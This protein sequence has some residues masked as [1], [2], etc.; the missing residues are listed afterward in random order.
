MASCMWHLSTGVSTASSDLRVLYRLLPVVVHD[1]GLIHHA[2]QDRGSANARAT[3]LSH[4][5]S[6]FLQ[7]RGA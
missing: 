3:P 7:V 5:D 2:L 4:T 6:I 1:M